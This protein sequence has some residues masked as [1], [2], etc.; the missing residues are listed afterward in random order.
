MP[1]ALLGNLDEDPFADLIAEHL[2]LSKQ[3]RRTETKET[4]I[5]SKG[6]FAPA[7][8]GAGTPGTFTYGSANLI[9]WTRIG[10][11]VFVNGRLQITAT[12][13]APV[14]VLTI[15]AFPF[16]GVSNSTMAIAGVMNMEWNGIDL[17]AG[18]TSISLQMPNG[19]TSGSPIISGDNVVFGNLTGAHLTAG[20]AYDLRMGG[21]YR[22]F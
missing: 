10:N 18:Y 21:N 9:E 19:S 5:Y 6:S 14:G 3:V 13:V 2:K 7:L 22:I 12:S 11:R 8:V 4:P 20:G 17:P 16:A 15:T 1:S